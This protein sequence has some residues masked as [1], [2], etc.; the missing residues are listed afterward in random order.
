MFRKQTAAL[1]FALLMTVVIHSQA[2]AQEPVE[3]APMPLSSSNAAQYVS[4]PLSFAQQTARFEAE[5]RR[6]RMEWNKWIGHSPL[7]PHMNA[8]YM[9]NGV[10]RFY[11]PSR[12]VI[13]SAGYSHGWYW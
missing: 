1:A 2:V 11:I 10:Q 9:S 4:A 5:Q 12:A 13:V 6:M 3:S 8:S 7:R